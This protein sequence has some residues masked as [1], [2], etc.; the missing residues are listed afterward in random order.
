MGLVE[1]NAAVAAQLAAAEET[2]EVARA[3]FLRLTADFDNFRK[4]TVRPRPERYSLE[5]ARKRHGWAYCAPFGDETCLLF[6]GPR[7]SHMTTHDILLKSWACMDTIRRH[8][9]WQVCCLTTY[10]LVHLTS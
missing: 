9:S 3:Q 10:L 6:S 1:Q 5:L 2:G 8:T 7:R 4:R